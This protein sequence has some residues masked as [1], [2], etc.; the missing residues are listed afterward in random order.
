MVYKWE[1]HRE[2]CYELY[3]NQGKTVPQLAEYL[4]TKYGFNPR[5]RTFHHKFR[6]WQFPR[7]HDP[8]WKKEELVS[9]VKELWSKNLNGHEM[10]RVLTEEDGYELDARDLQNI[11]SRHGF[12][13]RTKGSAFGHPTTSDRIERLKL[14]KTL[15]DAKRTRGGSGAGERQESHET[16][17]SGEDNDEEMEDEEVEEAGQEERLADIV[18]AVEAT[19]EIPVQDLSPEE[20]AAVEMRKQQ[21]MMELQAESMA[22]WATKKRRRRIKEYAGMPAD[23]PC[24]PRYPSETTL[25]ET[26]IILGLDNEAYMTV[27]K[28]FGT[29]CEQEGVI[30]KT[31]AGPEKWEALKDQL[32]RQSIHLRSCMWDQTDI[33]RKKLAIDLI[34]CDVTKARRILTT[35]L[36]VPK[37]KTILNLDPEQGRQIRSSI[38][39]IL[40]QEK[41]FSRHFEGEEHWQEILAKWHNSSELMRRLSQFERPDCPDPDRQEKARALNFLARDA[42][43]R[44]RQEA[45]HQGRNVFEEAANPPGLSRGPVVSKAPK[46]PKPPKP[47]P[48]PQEPGGPKRR[49]RPPGTGK[50]Q[51]AQ[52]AEERAHTVAR[53]APIE[54]SDEEAEPQPVDPLLD[55]TSPELNFFQPQG[56]QQQPVPQQHQQPPVPASMAVFYKLHSNT[57]LPT[58]MAGPRM[59]I[60]TVPQHPAVEQVRAAALAKYPGAM[61]FAIEGIVKDGQGGE[62]P[63]PVSDDMELEAYLQHIQGNANVTGHSAAPTFVVQLMA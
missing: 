61:C 49:G 18:P 32:I 40:A 34:C 20:L 37:A 14:M 33:E 28:A 45:V 48:P 23:P 27:R 7:K 43:R 31:I 25:G 44:Y 16:D 1:T 36:S 5:P 11:R 55:P 17:E 41:F 51:K 59:W 39:L 46:P 50:N 19:P 42:M 22:K 21:R 9:R 57:A 35:K 38:Y 13:L 63:L 60:S 4:R 52:A 58:H 3:V 6:Q 8:A 26:K 62:L 2:E 47:P 15:K 54:I 12:Y 29:L 56:L 24:P 53:L 30:K 10:L